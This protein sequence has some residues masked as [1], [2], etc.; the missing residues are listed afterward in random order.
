MQSNSSG[1]GPIF[2]T[3]EN[4]SPFKNIYHSF[5]LTFPEVFYID[6]AIRNAYILL[7]SL[8]RP[9]QTLM[10]IVFVAKSIKIA[11]LFGK[12]SDYSESLRTAWKSF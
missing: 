11:I 5:S 3:S 4:A 10:Y 12:S 9:L 8:N 2:E 7:W 1:L 6:D